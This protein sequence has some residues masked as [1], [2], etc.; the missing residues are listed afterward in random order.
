MSKLQEFQHVGVK[1]G[2]INK[3]K[4]QGMKEDIQS[5]EQGLGDWTMPGRDKESDDLCR[6]TMTDRATDKQRGTPHNIIIITS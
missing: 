3:G 1:N 6:Q 5:N 2:K 4:V